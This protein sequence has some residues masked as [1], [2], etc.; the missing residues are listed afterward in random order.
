MEAAVSGEEFDFAIAFETGA[1]NDV[2][3]AVDAVAVF[4]GV[5]AAFDFDHVHV[6]GVEL[7]TDV[8]GNVGVGHGDAVDHPG[9]LMTAA[10]VELVVNHVGARGI[11]GDEVEAVGPSGAGRFGDSLAAHGDGS[12]GGGRDDGLRGFADFDTPGDAGGIG[13]EGAPGR[14][15][16]GDGRQRD[17][18]AE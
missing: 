11:G 13:R 4:G 3:R 16:G 9:D 2:E 12:R 18:F 10:D 8:G 6:L 14:G 1:R 15:V 7:R 17:V 5:A